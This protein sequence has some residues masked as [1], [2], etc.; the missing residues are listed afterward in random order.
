MTTPDQRIIE[1]IA[2]LKYMKKVK[3]AVEFCQ[4]IGFYRQNLRNV[5]LGTQS[6]TIDH[7]E[8]ICKIYDVNANWILG[9]S[10][11]LYNNSDETLPI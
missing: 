7:I 11:K 6:F 4:N 5:R 3:S 2:Y 1:L 8:K 9:L 10:D